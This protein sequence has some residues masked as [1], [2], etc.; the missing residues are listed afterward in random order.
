MHRNQDIQGLAS[1]A[2]VFHRGIGYTGRA[3]RAIVASRQEETNT[4]TNPQKRVEWRT[5]DATTQKQYTD[6][7]LCLTT[8]PSQ[9]GLNTTLYEDF[10]WVHA[11]L[12]EQIHFVAQ[13]LP[14]HRY[15]VH[16]YETQLRNCGY[17]GIM[18]YW[19][20]TVDVADPSKS[21]IWDPVRGF[22]GDGVGHHHFNGVD[23]ILDICVQDGPFA[24]MTLHYTRTEYSEHCLSRNFNNGLEFP[25]DMLSFAYSPKTMANIHSIPEYDWF[26]INLEGNPHGAVHSA[27]NGD[28]GPSS[29]P[30]DPIFFLHHTQ[31]DRIWWLWQQDKPEH[32]QNYSGRKTQTES[33]DTMSSSLEDIMPF[34]GLADDLKLAEV[35][36]T[37]SSI[38]CYEY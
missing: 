28:M 5:L 37:Q 20:W 31:I 2:A 24:N 3:E 11:H 32:L 1:A 16:L 29:S 19:D 13:F 17:D 38:L 18:A 12:N 6:A 21:A 7:V 15:F 27:I 35:M 26:R 34:L 9:L 30:N 8:K 25:G 36:T 23:P 10:V 22:G 4:C 33:E 14:W